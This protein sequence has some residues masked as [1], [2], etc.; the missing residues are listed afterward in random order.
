MLRSALLLFL[1]RK[2]SLSE[3]SLK[4]NA[5][6]DVNETRQERTVFWLSYPLRAGLQLPII[7]NTL[8]QQTK[9]RYG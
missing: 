1:G 5:E 4:A 7:K 9:S 6:K 3:I 8:H 2:G